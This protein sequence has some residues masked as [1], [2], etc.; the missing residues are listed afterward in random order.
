MHD[1]AV[2]RSLPKKGTGAAKT[3]T[4]FYHFHY[5]LT[6]EERQLCERVRAF[7]DQEVTP[8]ISSYWERGEL[9][10]ELV[11]KLARLNIA[12]D[13]IQGHGCPGIKRP[14]AGMISAEIARG[15]AGVT[16]ILGASC[17]AMYA[18][19]MFGSEEQKSQWLPTM[20]TLE[21]IGAFASTEP[22]HGSDVIHMETSARRDGDSWVIN[23]SKRWISNASFADVIVVWARTHTGQVNAFLVEKG[24]PGF[25]ARVIRGKNVMR[26]AWQTDITLQ[27]VRV[28]VSNRLPHAHSFSDAM[29]VLSLGRYRVAWS[30]IGH[31]MAC[32]EYALAYVKNRKQFGK[33]LASFQLVQYKLAQML[34]EI[35]SLQ[36][37][38]YRLGQL[39]DEGQ[40]TAGMVSLAKMQT[41]S[42]ARKIAADAR[43]LLGGNG[44]LLE[45]HVIRHQGDIE[46]HFTL[47]G[48]DHMQALS[49][50]LEITGLQAF[51]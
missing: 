7:S 3:S 19:D 10:F 44:I 35:T 48:T 33:P 24:T 29:K 14:V 36:T 11:P 45:H 4:D 1:P 5:L 17:L 22:D 6:E 18:I 47:E 20:A 49:I 16:A 25:E 21:R 34:A 40:Y 13:T 9:P 8:I 28:P 12:G 51:F 42:K 50:G 26:S 30:A 23:G 31:A 37:L 38:C 41:T 46:A 32:Y 43:D 15:D 27:N 2:S 39:M